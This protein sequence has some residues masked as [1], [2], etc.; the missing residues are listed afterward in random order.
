M[1]L[2]K[3]LF[4]KIASKENKSKKYNDVFKSLMPPPPPVPFQSIIN[5]PEKSSK[6]TEK[7]QPKKRAPNKI[8]SQSVNIT[9]EEL[10]ETQ[11]TASAMPR[12]QSVK[13]VKKNNKGE[14]AVHL[15]VMNEDINQL[16]QLL[17]DPI[18]DVNAKDN[19]GWTALHEVK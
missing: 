3:W 4:E 10:A 1:L 2:I 17:Q 9:V 12:S 11:L 13:R 14:T 5:R 15:A 16:K 6:S 7:K 19:A 8:R 18:T